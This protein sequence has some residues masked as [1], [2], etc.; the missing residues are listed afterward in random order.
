MNN[1][2]ATV[3]GC[4]VN[5]Y[6]N[7]KLSAMKYIIPISIGQFT[8]LTL[9]VLSTD[10]E[11][12]DQG[13]VRCFQCDTWVEDFAEKKIWKRSG[14]AM[15]RYGVCQRC[16]DALK[17]LPPNLQRKFAEKCEKNLR[18]ALEGGSDV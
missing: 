13:L 7:K 10:P 15:I 3:S 11:K 16:A 8:S 17:I 6:L 12:R 14:A 9:T 4:G 2:K 5:N 18:T 1:K